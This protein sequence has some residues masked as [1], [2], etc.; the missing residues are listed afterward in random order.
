LDLGA[1]GIQAA[2]CLYVLLF[3]VRRFDGTHASLQHPQCPPPPKKWLLV[4]ERGKGLS[5]AANLRRKP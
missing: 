4:G 5:I 2:G 3:D 1:A